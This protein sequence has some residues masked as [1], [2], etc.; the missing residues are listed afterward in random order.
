MQ[1]F[2]EFLVSPLVSDPTLLHITSTDNIV[3]VAVPSIDMGRIIGKRG[4][5]IFHL[6]VLVATYSKL[7]HLPPKY[8]QIKEL[9]S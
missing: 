5:A 1:K 6:R 8:I 3:V 4:Q 2:I 7:H 9:T